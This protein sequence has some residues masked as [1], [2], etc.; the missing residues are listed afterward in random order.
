[1]MTLRKMKTNHT[2]S[3]MVEYEFLQKSAEESILTPLNDKLGQK[4]KL[5]YAEKI[6]CVAC[7]KKSTK[8][9][10]QGHCF[11]CF[12]TL[13]ECDSCI[14]SPE[15]C[16]FEQGSCRNS[17][18]GNTHC[19]IPHTVYLAN[20]SGVKVGITRQNQQ[21]TRWMDQGAIQAIELGRVSTRF[22][23]GQVECAFKNFVTDRTS[24]QKMLKGG[25]ESL[26]MLAERARLIGEWPTTI[27]MIETSEAI[28]HEFSYPVIEYPLKV[29]SL[30]LEKTPEIE[31]TLM[32]I[33]GQY[34]LLDVGVINIRKFSGYE[35]EMKLG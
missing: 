7:G 5:N 17:E 13:P 14:M 31:G 6:W 22:L 24:W 16:H 10:N 30:D 20:S 28:V 27:P 26:D 23:S 2:T 34:L 35:V 32:G 33:K 3:G 29:K 19:N 25:N 12:Q 1:M 18:W 15:K 21:K 4:I 8:S 11:R 9:F